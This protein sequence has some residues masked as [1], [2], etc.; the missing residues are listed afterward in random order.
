MKHMF[1]GHRK[2][3]KR[4]EGHKERIQDQIRMIKITKF[5]S[6]MSIVA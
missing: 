2:R 6:K 1:N 4:K 5:S 3:K